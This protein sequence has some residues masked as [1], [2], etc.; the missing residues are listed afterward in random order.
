MTDSETQAPIPA[1]VDGVLVPADKLAVHRQGLRHQ[2]VSVFVTDGQNILLQQRAVTK[3]HT[4]GLWANT[5]CT[6]PH[7]CRPRQGCRIRR[8]PSELCVAVRDLSAACPFGYLAATSVQPGP[9]K[10]CLYGP[11]PNHGRFQSCKP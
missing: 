3:Y 10:L 1:W 2:A 8:F 5:C 6:T 4:P 11:V 9:R 7:W